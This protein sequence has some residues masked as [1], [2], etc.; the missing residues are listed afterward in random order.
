MPKCVEVINQISKA[1]LGAIVI[2]LLI[3]FIGMFYYWLWRKL[4][5]KED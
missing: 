3:Y 4:R 5:G 2:F 1:T